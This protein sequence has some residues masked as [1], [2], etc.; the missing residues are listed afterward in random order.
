[1]FDAKRQL[2]RILLPHTRHTAVPE[3][4]GA[5]D[6]LGSLDTALLVVGLHLLG[7]L[8]QRFFG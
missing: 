6:L 5:G 4:D 8:T 1:M 3:M 2:T 7:I